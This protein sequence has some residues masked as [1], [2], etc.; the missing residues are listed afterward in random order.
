MATLAS[1]NISTSGLLATYSAATATTGD[2]FLPATGTFLH[3][4]NANAGSVNV[5][6]TTPGTVDGLSITDRTVAVA[7]ATEKF[8]SLPDTLYRE[9][10]GLGTVICTPNTS[11]T[12]AVVRI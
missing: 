7:T 11:V 9:S 6:I 10:D 3:V 12:L 2:R 1:Q 8:I 5:V 4:K